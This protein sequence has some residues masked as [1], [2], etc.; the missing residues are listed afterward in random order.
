MMLNKS[1]KGSVGGG[2]A[3]EKS[4]KT[5]DAG[6]KSVSEKSQATCTCRNPFEESKSK[7][8]EFFVREGK[9]KRMTN[10]GPDFLI[11]GAV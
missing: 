6:G 3:G 1:E 9:D 11:S 7:Q 8:T 4:K 5:L 10:N 2:E